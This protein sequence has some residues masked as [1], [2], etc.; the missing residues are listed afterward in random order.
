MKIKSKWQDYEFQKSK[1][2]DLSP[3]EYEQRIKEICEKCNI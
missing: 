1:L 2:Q 3:D